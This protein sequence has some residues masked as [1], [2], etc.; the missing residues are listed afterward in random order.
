MLLLFI[1]NATF[2][3]Y[4]RYMTACETESTRKGITYETSKQ[5]SLDLNGIVVGNPLTDLKS[6][7]ESLAGLYYN[8]TSARMCTRDVQLSN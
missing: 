6:Y 5:L 7:T 2:T 1:V 8:E 3:S 4:G